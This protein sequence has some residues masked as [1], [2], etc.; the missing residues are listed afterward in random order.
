MITVPA[1]CQQV[2]WMLLP[3]FTSFVCRG[4][5]IRFWEMKSDCIM[6]FWKYSF[7]LHSHPSSLAVLFHFYYHYPN[8]ILLESRQSYDFA[9]E[10]SYMSMRPSKVLIRDLPQQRTAGRLRT[11]EWRKNVVRDSAFPIY[12]TFVRH[13]AVLRVPAILLRELT[14][15][16]HED[17]IP[18]A[19]SG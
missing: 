1:L 3:E 11:A 19:T 9:K 16:L 13:S 5:H 8:Q 10:K 7:N 6:K 17:N 12:A 4:C 2:L 15:D 14:I 18:L